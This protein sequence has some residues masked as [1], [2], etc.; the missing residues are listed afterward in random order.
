MKKSF[1]WMALVSGI[2]VLASC[3]KNTM[4][5][6]MGSWYLRTVTTEDLANDTT[7]VTEYWEDVIYDFRSDG[8]YRR[9]EHD[10]SVSTGS[11][12]APQEGEMFLDGIRYKIIQREKYEFTIDKAVLETDSLMPQWYFIRKH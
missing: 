1:V 3:K 6:L 12:S 8:V 2:L 7:Y 4:E 9:F 10:D 5:Y 11:W